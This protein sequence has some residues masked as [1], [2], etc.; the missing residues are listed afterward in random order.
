[1]T[2]EHFLL[3]SHQLEQG[4]TSQST[5]P[6]S[7]LATSSSTK[8]SVRLSV[9]TPRSGIT[10]FDLRDQTPLSS[11]T[12]GPSY[13]PSTPA[14]SRST[15]STSTESIRVKSARKT[16]VGVNAGESGEVWSWLEDER[17]DG[18]VEGEP[19]KVV[20]PIAS[21]LS[22]LLAPRTL[23]EHLVLLAASGALSLAHES[24]LANPASLPTTET[25]P[26]SQTLHLYPIGASTTLLPASVLSLIPASSRAHLAF[27][28]RTFSSPTPAP[29][30][31]V[32]ISK[33]SFKKQ[34]RPSSA[35]VIEAA[36]LLAAG[37]TEDAVRSQVELALLDPEVMRDG[38]VGMGIV[39]LGKVTVPG[40]QVVVSED[41]YVSALSSSSKTLESY[42]LSF[43]GTASFASVY[44]DLFTEAVSTDAHLTLVALKSLAL[45][46][47][48]LALPTA[49]IL[50]LHSSFV[51]LTAARPSLKPASDDLP[52]R[53]ASLIW[54]VRLGALVLDADVQIPAAAFPPSTPK[55]HV[56]LA[57]SSISRTSAA[58]V[59]A[60]SAGPTGRSLLFVLPLSSLPSSSVLAAVV[61][62]HAL[63]KKYLAL[64]AESASAKARK[65]EPV[66]HPKTS[67]A[68]RAM[69]AQSEDARGALLD[70]LEAVLSGGNIGDAQVADAEAAF[71]KFVAEDTTRLREYHSKKMADEDEKDKVRREDAKDEIALVKT[72]SSKYRAA[73]RRIDELVA[74]AGPSSS[75]IDITAKRI[76]GVSDVY[77]FKYIETRK[78][79]DE[80]NGKTVVR[81]GREKA[82]KNIATMEPTFPSSFVNALL[83]VCFPEGAELDSDLVSS[84]SSRISK[85]P[86]GIVSYLLKRSLVADSHLPAGVSKVLA[87]A[88]DWPNVLLALETMPDIPEST[89]VHL[90]KTIIAASAVDQITPSTSTS[91]PFPPPPLLLFL[92]SFVESPSTPSTLRQALQQQLSA[93][94]VLPVLEILDAWLGWWAKHGGGGG[95]MGEER[96]QDWKAE[97][98][99][100]PK[101]LPTNPFVALTEGESDANDLTPPRVEDILPLVQAILDAH[102]ITLL[103]HRSSHSLLRRLARH[104]DAHLAIQA[105]L[106]SLLGA[107]TIFARAKEDQRD[108]KSKGVVGGGVATGFG[109]QMKK[110][111]GATMAARVAAQEKHAEVGEYQVDKFW[112]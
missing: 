56:R 61:G 71:V 45:S 60:P 62:K 86:I 33:K 14:V 50:A 97:G 81:T 13:T 59:V 109:E 5:L 35:S 2:E 42:R 112:L 12:L 4:Y 96:G 24:D 74:D 6:S 55:R 89:T 27:A 105:D 87:R 46:P 108:A 63:T 84:S 3:A 40:S 73:R 39:S 34:K 58:L 68:K 51:L 31:L 8:H 30:S 82:L 52:T 78:A 65:A 98:R 18:S 100:K 37:A 21:P 95:Q 101:R 47:T 103:L 22:A 48:S 104:V 91:L 29:E 75:W 54:D 77:R 10:V 66:R 53:V 19:T 102:F 57:L 23:P 28:V 106:A 38:V 49:T 99:N 88:G 43:S 107:L 111:L 44:A 16:W 9:S 110:N 11:I 26:S 15:P 93:V 17:K 25:L 92:A 69:Y 72:T 36:D 83:R 79:L 20:Y 94:E 85:H 41:G 80:K 1:M 7:S 67:E 70:H 64:E 76:P 32:E 90:L